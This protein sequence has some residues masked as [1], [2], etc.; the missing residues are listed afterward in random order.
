MCVWGGGLVVLMGNLYGAN[1]LISKPGLVFPYE[2]MPPV[3]SEFGIY[4]GI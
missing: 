2:D 3:E 4:F 1:I